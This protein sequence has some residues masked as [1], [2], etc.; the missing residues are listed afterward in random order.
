MVIA[1]DNETFLIEQ[2]MLAPP[3]VCV[4]L[5][6]TVDD[7]DII[8]RRDPACY[9]TVRYLLETDEPLVGANLP[10]DVAVWCAEWPELLD[11]VFECY[12]IDGKMRDV[13]TRQKLID[14]AHGQ[15]RGYRSATTGAWIEHRYS[16]AAC[17]ER[18]DYPHKLDKDTWRLRYN[19]LFDID[20]EDWPEGARSYSEHDSRS[21]LWVHNGQEQY[22][23]LLVD[24]SRQARAHWALHLMSAWGMRTDPKMVAMLKILVQKSLDDCRELLLQ[25]DPPLL[26][27]KKDGNY[28]REVKLAKLYAQVA[29]D[30][31]PDAI[32]VRT[33]TKAI[34]LGE[35]AAKQLG[36]PVIL[37]FQQYGSS[38]TVMDR[39]RE[40]EAGIDAPIHTRFEWLAVSGRTTSSNPNIQAR[41][42]KFHAAP[43]CSHAKEDRKTSCGTCGEPYYVAG[44]REAFIPSGEGN[45]FLITDV[46]GLELRTIAQTAIK[47]VG[48]SRMAE[49]LNEGR[50]PHLEVAASLLDI[51]L[52]EAYERKK[53]LEEDYELYLARQTG[54]IVD[55]GLNARLGWRGLINQGRT[56][57][58]V[59]I[60]RAGATDAID[61]YYATWPEQ[62]EF[63]DWVDRQCS[64]TGVG[65][66][67]HL[68]SGREQGLVPPTVMSNTFSQGL[69]ADATKAALFALTKSCYVGP[70]PL[71]G[72]RPVNYPHDEY[73][74]ETSEANLDEKSIETARIICQAANEFLPDVPIPELEMR[75][76]ACR[77]W[78][79]GAREVRNEDGTLDV[80][81]WDAWLRRPQ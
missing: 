44:D 4:S 48:Y 32:P 72:S 52:E 6:D 47:I 73:I 57:Y 71:L 39:V 80:W 2:G 49:V 60:S 61:A 33:K 18:H 54:K 51:T 74:I 15:Y 17:A 63:H 23:N 43:S 35:D 58:G 62:R 19:E 26:K 50:D 3:L 24:E 65:H 81:E 14:I 67:T 34:S 16:L 8:H 22:G 40:L 55:F 7:A 68:F 1:A 13:Q 36:D 59:T 29:W 10:F 77:R 38:S 66:V 75:P 25:Q 20:V 12:M 53:N 78:S 9:R 28:K 11:L 64:R 27:L 21:T 45:V 30:K 41:Q 37:A 31:L 5:T 76:Y 56:K 69:G 46:P 42:N 79:K 70:G